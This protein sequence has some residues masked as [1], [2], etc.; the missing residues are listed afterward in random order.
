MFFLMTALFKKIV[1]GSLDF[2]VKWYKEQELHIVSLECENVT[3]HL[4]C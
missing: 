2:S 1:V 3:K 4:S